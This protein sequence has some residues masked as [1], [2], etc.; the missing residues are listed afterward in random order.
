M[1]TYLDVLG[2]REAHWITRWSEESVE[3]EYHLA[4]QAYEAE[5]EAIEKPTPAEEEQYAYVSEAYESD[6]DIL[7]YTDFFRED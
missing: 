5:Y 2:A 3:L 4:F 7:G 1:T 6:L